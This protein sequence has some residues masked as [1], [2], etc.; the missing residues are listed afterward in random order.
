MMRP[1][2]GITGVTGMVGK[3]LLSLIKN[4]QPDAE[5]RLGVRQPDRLAD[6]PYPVVAVDLKQPG[7][8]AAFCQGCAIIVN[9]AGPSALYGLNVARAAAIAGA[10][11]IDAF[12]SYGPDSARELDDI[13]AVPGAASVI[14][15][16]GV[17]PGLSELLPMAMASRY[18]DNVSTLHAAAGGLE[19]CSKG[20]GIDILMSAVAGYG[21]ATGAD[22]TALEGFPSHIIA[23][24]FRSTDFVRM[25]ETFGCQEAHWYSV[26]SSSRVSEVIADQCHQLASAGEL[27]ECMMASAADKLSEVADEQLAGRTPW[28]RMRIDMSGSLQ[29]EPLCYRALLQTP[30]SYG[31]TALTMYATLTTVLQDLSLHG[32]FRASEIVS[33]ELMVA[34]IQQDDRHQLHFVQLPIHATSFYSNENETE[35]G[36]L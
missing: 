14:T 6:S 32:H 31:L 20:A 12:G 28:Y 18:F 4:C 35:E 15:G 1:V 22:L 2:I 33:P 16:A 30:A 9:C 13:M 5:I 26:F 10:H 17:F 29:G 7:S 23:K 8:L 34:L 3:A 19:P 11:C 36:F 21:Q 27:T 25:T 24:P